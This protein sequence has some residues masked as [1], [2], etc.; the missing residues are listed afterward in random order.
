M[1]GLALAGGLVTASIGPVG[2]AAAYP[3]AAVTVSGHGWGAGVGMGQWGA[4]GYAIGQDAGLGPQTYQWIVGHFYSPASLQTV[5]GGDAQ[6][7]RVAMTEDNDQF[8]IASAA[9]GVTVPGSASAG[10][11]MFQGGTGG[12]WTVYTGPGCAGPWTA[13]PSTATPVTQAVDGGAIQLCLG[14]GNLA[15][16]GQLQ[17]V[18][19]SAGARRTVNIVNLGQYLSDVVPSESPAGWGTLG[20][21]TGSPQGQPWGFQALEA[22]AVAA[23]SYV[24]SNPMGYGGYADTCD[25]TCQSY[26]GTR[27]ESPQ[28]TLAVAETAGQVMEMPGGAVATTQYSSSTGGET[29]S[30][31]EGSPFTPVADDGDAVCVPGACNG[32]HTWQASVPVTSIVAM[33]PQIGTLESVAVTGRNGLGDLGGRVTSLSLV[34]SSSTVTLSGTQFAIDFGLRSDWF[35]VA[36]QPSGGIGGYWLAGQDGGLFAFG[37]APYLGSMGGRP[38]NS[39]IVGLAATGDAAGYW[40]VGADGGIFSFGDARFA[41][42]MGG[43]HLNRP[44]VGIAADPTTGG[45]WAVASDG[46]IFAFG[47]P[48]YGSTGG[49]P[50]NQPVVGMAVT[51]DGGGYW[52]VA[53]D[54]GIFA[55][56]DATFWG[57]TGSLHL[58]KPVV[59][60]AAAPYGLGYWL[61]ASDG[62]VFAFGSAAFAGAAAGTPAGA[63]TIGIVAT[64]DGRGYLL[65]NSAGMVD[66]FGDAPQLGDLTSVVASYG[67]HVVAV[68]PTPG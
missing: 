63:G 30:A 64:R 41:G 38:L 22:Q 50:L 14:A 46:G 60:M 48:F 62:G 47:A 2:R 12:T 67:G 7:V 43:Q 21:T 55:F 20:G 36:S 35:T 31:A 40:E 61:V 37:N 25:Q 56:G 23:R 11:V 29:A 1:A 65:V 49:T 6:T 18:L 42:S 39:P 45:Y 19:N 54:G 15:V 28:A 51:P 34:G 5:A 27:N 52:L 58:S 59:A 10:A 57:S 17:P 68:A 16:H 3:F 32:N 44:I 53:A 13:Q 24:L 4:L 66:N 8:L 9:N 26:P 33:F